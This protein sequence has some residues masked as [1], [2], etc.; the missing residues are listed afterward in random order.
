MKTTIAITCL[1]AV[2][3]FSSCSKDD[4]APEP[5]QQEKPLPEPEPENQAPSSFSVTTE[6]NKNTVKLNW[7]AA[8]DP[9]GDTITY[10]IML[11]DSLISSQTDTALDLTG[12]IFEKDYEGKIIADD[13]NE[14]QKEAS[15]SFTTSFLWLT[16]F[17]FDDFPSS[18][19]KYEY[20]D[21]EKL[22]T[23]NRPG[24]KINVVYDGEGRLFSYDYFTYE[25]N[26]VG[27][28]TKLSDGS[29]K[30]DLKILYNT[31]DQPKELEVTRTGSNNFNSDV[32]ATLTYNGLGRLS[33][34][35]K[36][37]IY[38]SNTTDGEQNSYERIELRYDNVGN[39][40]EMIT[41][42]S[43]DGL[44]YQINSM[45]EYS[46]D[47][48]KNPWYAIINRQFNFN[49]SITLGINQ[50]LNRNT[51]P[52]YIGGYELHILVSEHNLTS[53][54]YYN[55]KLSLLEERSYEY[56]YN[57]S[58][59]PTSAKINLSDRDGEE[60]EVSFSLEYLD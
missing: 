4:P 6:V 7:S 40:V 3:I 53:V 44:D 15:F 43:D 32:T 8:E 41:R 5:Q 20:D 39:V 24:N 10:S 33:R 13:G 14:H 9:D 25:W 22:I 31:E 34:I 60:E 35:D 18:G 2:L 23:L 17:K 58:D 27:Q 50:D 28:L 16:D 47:N 38:S 11:E 36:H 26:E 30:G 56:T 1:L 59:Y 49:S 55:D 37:S 29:G 42:N 52:T 54:K 12:L 51:P 48:Q 57:N 19:L 21:N 45:Y 46:Y